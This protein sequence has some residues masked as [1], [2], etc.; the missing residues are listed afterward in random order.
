MSRHSSSTRP[1]VRFGRGNGKPT[2]SIRELVRVQLQIVQGFDVIAARGAQKPSPERAQVIPSWP[3]VLVVTIRDEPQVAQAEPRNDECNTFGH[4]KQGRSK[5]CVLPG[6]A[7]GDGERIS[8]QLDGPPARE[9][10]HRAGRPALPRGIALR[11]LPPC[12]VSEVNISE[13]KRAS[14]RP[15]ACRRIERCPEIPVHAQHLRQG[16]GVALPDDFRRL[17]NEPLVEFLNEL[18]T[19]DA[20]PGRGLE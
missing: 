3:Q 17:P 15:A 11:A 9:Q 20:R 19:G 4:C 8:H 16:A 13:E 7:P 6:S 1:G 10:A 2:V 14:T 12:L 18:E 5:A